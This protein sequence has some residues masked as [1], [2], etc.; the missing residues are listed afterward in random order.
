LGSTVNSPFALANQILEIAEAATAT[1]VGG[2]IGV[3]PP[4]GAGGRAFVSP[5]LPSIDCFPFMAIFVSSQIVA[6]TNPVGPLASGHKRLTG[7]VPQVSF[8][9]VVAR[10]AP[11]MVNGKTLPSVAAMEV[12]AQMVDQ[13]MWA[14]TDA[15][16]KADFERTF[17]SCREFEH[18]GATPLDPTGGATGWT[19][20]WKATIEG[21]TEE[22]T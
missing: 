5:G 8:G 6:T 10:C 12:V 14:I 19:I 20:R 13:D 18:L 11:P 2:Q 1:T 4:V 7:L 9:M 22:T 3:D 15:M 17:G 16:R 21:I